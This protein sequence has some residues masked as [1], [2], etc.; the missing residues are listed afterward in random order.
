MSDGG[1]HEDPAAVGATCAAQARAVHR[2]CPAPHSC[3]IGLRCGPVGPALF[4]PTAAV[5]CRPRRGEGISD[6]KRPQAGGVDRTRLGRIGQTQHS[7]QRFLAR[8]PVAAQ[9]WVTGKPERGRFLGHRATAPFG[10][11]GDRVMACRRH[12]ADDQG[13]QRGEPVTHPT[14]SARIGD[15]LRLPGQTADLIPGS[16][17]AKSLQGGRGRE[18]NCDE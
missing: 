3:R 13:R 15:P 14:G 11:R 5:G 2:D 12:R 16:P 10:G 17:L 4:T 18:R 7:A 1:Q 8:Y 9:Q 6:R